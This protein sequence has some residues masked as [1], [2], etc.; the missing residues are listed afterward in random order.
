MIITIVFVFTFTSKE[1]IETITAATA[2]YFWMFLALT[3]VGLMICRTRFKGQF[4]GYRVPLYPLTPLLFVSA[5]FFM[6]YRSWVF[7]M[8]KDLGLVT[9]MLG[10]WVI[11]GI[12]LSFFMGQEKVP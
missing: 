2:P 8:E 5:C 7:M 10:L 3:V 4:S 12:V 1:G 6:V 9:L 11:G